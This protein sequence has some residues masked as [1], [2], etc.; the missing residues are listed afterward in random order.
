[1]QINPVKV[2]INVSESFYSQVKIGMPAEI[3][4]DVFAN[5]VIKGDEHE[6]KSLLDKIDN[7][8]VMAYDFHRPGVDFAGPV[9][10][11]GSNVGKRNIREV[12]EKIIAINLDKQK[13]VMCRFLFL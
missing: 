3:S 4:V 11:I 5:T 6:L 13:T 2:L 7:L 1:M 9:A 12:V 10:P 8:V